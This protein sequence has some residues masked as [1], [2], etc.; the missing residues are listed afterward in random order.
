MPAPTMRS[1]CCLMKLASSCF[2]YR[3]SLRRGTPDAAAAA[4][5]TVPA[6]FS[7]STKTRLMLEESAVAVRSRASS[8]VSTS[9]TFVGPHRQPEMLLY[10]V[11]GLVAAVALR[12]AGR[13]VSV[14]RPDGINDCGVFLHGLAV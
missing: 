13:R 10:Q 5:V 9:R 3:N 14:P 7:R 1:E 4:A 2:R 11:F 12:R 6:I 8:T